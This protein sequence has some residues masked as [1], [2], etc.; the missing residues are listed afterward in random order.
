[1]IDMAV[2][3]EHQEYPVVCVNAIV[4]ND[5]NQILLTKRAEPP[6]QGGW[7]IISG[8][9]DVQDDNLE[10][11]VR[12]EVKEE[13]NL[14]VEVTH[15][16]GV[17]TDTGGEAPA[18]SRFFVVQVAYVARVI[19]GSWQPSAEAAAHRWVSIEE[20][21]REKLIFNHT[22]VVQQFAD[23]NKLISANRSMFTEHFGKPYAYQQREYRRFA[24]K[25]LIINDKKEILLAERKQRPYVGAWDLPGGNML[26]G[27]TTTACLIREVKE[28]I[29]TDVTLGKLFHVY[30]DKGMSPKYAS[31]VALYF[32]DL[33]GTLQFEPNIEMGQ[34]QFFS[35]DALPKDIAYFNGV[36]LR[37]LRATL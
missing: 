7:G 33:V 1:M 8:Y 5:K 11:S 17:I 22:E 24:C 21:R 34:C 28:E 20:A 31:T 6:Y 35:L 27:E 16:V 3:T 30:S 15:L 36:A 37:D 29:G 4:V 13:T 25:A 19:G 12:R 26:V 10:A 14:D 9:A 2:Y 18:D 23:A 32:A